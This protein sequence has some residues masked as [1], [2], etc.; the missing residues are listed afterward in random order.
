MDAKVFNFNDLNGDDFPDSLTGELGVDVN[1][2]DY[3]CISWEEYSNDLQDEVSDLETD[4]I[5]A[6]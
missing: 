1:T 2:D 4:L 5:F 6:N 3:S